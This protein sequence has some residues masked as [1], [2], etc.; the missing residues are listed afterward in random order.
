MKKIDFKSLIRECIKEELHKWESQEGTPDEVINL[1]H[2]IVSSVQRANKDPKTYVHILKQGGNTGNWFIAGQDNGK[3]MAL[4]YNKDLKRWYLR[5]EKGKSKPIDDQDDLI[6]IVKN[7]VKYVDK[8]LN[9]ESFIR[10]CILDVIYESKGPKFA[11]LKK[12]KKPLSSEERKIVM[13]AGAVWHHGINGEES[14]AIMKSV[15]DGKTWYSCHT[16]RAYQV[17][18]TLKGA[19]QSFKFI[20]TTA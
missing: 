8:K 1:T 4:I 6:S 13:D 2:H 5:N 7:W 14:P 15:I 16:H 19:I 3:N 12:N 9:A 17:R 18:P 11:T 10:E 20:K